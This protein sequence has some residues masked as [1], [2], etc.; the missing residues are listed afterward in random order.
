[1]DSSNFQLSTSSQSSVKTTMNINSR[2]YKNMTTMVTVALLSCTMTG[3][4]AHNS[5]SNLFNAN[6]VITI[7]TK[8]QGNVSSKVSFRDRYKKI[9]CAKW[10]KEAYDN[11]SIGD[12]VYIED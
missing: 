11:K 12:V 6:H 8:H 9:S 10:Y 7:C 2:D 4:Q 1:M 3:T 5:A